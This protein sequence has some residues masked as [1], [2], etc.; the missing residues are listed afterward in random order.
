MLAA[1]VRMNV[2]GEVFMIQIF[3]PMANH[4]VKQEAGQC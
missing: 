1:V 3:L 4:P 2:D